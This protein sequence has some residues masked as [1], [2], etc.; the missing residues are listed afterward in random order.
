MPEP[1][2]N[3][4][5]CRLEQELGMA[6]YPDGSGLF[7]GALKRLSFGSAWIALAAVA[8]CASGCEIPRD[9]L[10]VRSSFVDPGPL[11]TIT[12]P[13]NLLYGN[14]TCTFTATWISG[15]SPY[16]IAWNFG[17]GATNIPARAASSPATA[18]ATWLDS[19]HTNSYTVTATVTDAQ[20][21]SGAASAFVE[22]WPTQNI[23][24][25]IEEVGSEAGKLTVVVSD[26][27][28]DS[29]V[30]TVSGFTGMTVDYATKAAAA[31][32]T[33]I[34]V[35][36]ADDVLAGTSSEVD[37]VAEDWTGG[38][39]K[40]TATVSI[41]A[42][43]LFPGKLYAIPLSASVST[44]DPVTVV[45]ATGVTELPFQFMTGAGMVVDGDASYVPNSFNTG[46]PGGARDDAD[47]VWAGITSDGGFLLAPDGL[48]Q[49]GPNPD[50]T[51]QPG[52]QRIDFNVTPLGGSDVAS[53]EG[54]L[55]NFQ[56]VYSQP[57]EKHIGFQEFNGIPRTYYTSFA[58]GVE[59]YWGAYV[60]GTIVVTE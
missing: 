44:G 5:N 15:M 26:A 16:T 6:R 38:T 46:L 60:E 18:D 2:Y 4:D 19:P 7:G 24:P 48:I 51:L 13:I 12:P 25:V 8:L 53:A 34:F 9:T 55:F 43:G 58:D 54:A 3:M 42:F 29:V 30:L 49:P 39:D 52:T 50:G 21:F 20:G 35:F 57:G 27:D 32:G 28:D 40:A 22:V 14:E 31:T 33:A 47:G 45:V 37:I 1:G 36:E 41:P 59:R 10:N 17:G 11:V 23:P 56:L